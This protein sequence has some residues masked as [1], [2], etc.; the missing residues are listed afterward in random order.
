MRWSVRT[1]PPPLT[2]STQNQVVPACA[3]AL[4]NQ[5]IERCV[6]E[7]Q[8]SRSAAT[9][10][11]VR[12]PHYCKSVRSVTATYRMTNKP[13]PTAPTF[14][15]A[16]VLKPLQVF[17]DESCQLLVWP[18]ACTRA[19][20]RPLT[21]LQ[22]DDAKQQWVM[23]V[24][25]PVTAQFV[26]FAG[27]VLQTLQQTNRFLNKIVKRTST[28]G[29][30]AAAL[31]DTDKITLQLYLDVQEFGAQ[32]DTFKARNVKSFGDL[33]ELVSAGEAFVVGK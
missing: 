11:P 31:S 4:Q 18:Q 32:L 6:A 17:L 3:Q 8:V 16:S 33:V 26:T 10:A 2:P 20:R 27:D 9:D 12:S 22:S 28:S 19:W 29:N 15:V 1:T 30:G 21:A 13:A 25:E 5:I 7:L 24:A 23:S 14:Y